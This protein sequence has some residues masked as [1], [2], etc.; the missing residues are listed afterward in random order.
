MARQM[1][2]GAEILAE[3]Q[4][5]EAHPASAV[6]IGD[7]P[8]RR[9]E[10]PEEQRRPPPSARLD[11]RLNVFTTI[12]RHPALYQAWMPFCAQLL[13]HS[14]FSPRERELLIIRTA[15]LCGCA[16]ELDH[17][18]R[19]G[20]RVGLNDRDL[21]ALTGQGPGFWTHRERMLLAAADELHAKHTIG[22]ATWHELSAL[23]TPEQLVELPMLVG[24]YVLLA[25]TL[26]SLRVPLDR[27]PG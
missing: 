5:P 10:P 23:L 17:H 13:L 9:G 26:G 20:S 1:M 21:A 3:R 22:E 19:L 2:S 12:A 4:A 6:E 18:L 24:H 8:L 15:S 11:D 7:G 16:Y 14:V 25:G 27:E